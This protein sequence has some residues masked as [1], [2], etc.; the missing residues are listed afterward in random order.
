MP[1]EPSN[2][3]SIPCPLLQTTRILCD[4][5]FIVHHKQHGAGICLCL[6]RTDTVANISSTIICGNDI[7][8][9]FHGLHT[10]QSG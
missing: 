7:G 4:R 3:P 8:N 1:I 6:Y 10:S 2:N 5:D 9:Q